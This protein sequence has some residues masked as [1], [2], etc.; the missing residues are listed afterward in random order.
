MF[1]RYLFNYLIYLVGKGYAQE[2]V[3]WR[4]SPLAMLGKYLSRN[5]IRSVTE[6]SRKTAEEYLSSLK[7]GA[8]SPRGKPIS[9][10][11]YRDHLIALDDFFKW[12]LVREK[13]LVNPMADAHEAKGERP[14]RLP[15]ALTEEEMMK[16]IQAS[17]PTTALGLRD[18]AVLELLYSTGIRRR[19]LVNL[20]V[21]DFRLESHELF[22]VNGKG[23]K[24]R[25]VPVGEWACYFTEAYVK[26]VRPWQVYSPTEKALFVQHRNGRRLSPRSVKDIVER[27]TA[28]SGVGRRVSPHTF[29]HAMATHMLRNHA[30]LRHIQ[31]ILGHTSLR[32]TQVYTHVNIE[33]LKEVVRRAH[34]HGRRVRLPA[35]TSRNKIDGEA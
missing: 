24:D 35:T 21:G 12:L 7:S 8:F 11:T 14:L 4:K 34:P 23:G 19:E 25:V 9:D 30:D 28:K 1:E 26:N 6:V 17:V 13:L 15:H 27:A 18:R 16:I 5:G 20:T 29:R 10:G 32:S 3:R 22:I 31:A 33:D 2:T